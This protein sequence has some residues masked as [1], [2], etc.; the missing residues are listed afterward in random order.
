MSPNP[1]PDSNFKPIHPCSMFII[2]FV[3]GYN[4]LRKW[5][6][7]TEK[8][9]EAMAQQMAE[10]ASH[11]EGQ[12]LPQVIQDFTPFAKV[13]EV[14]MIFERADACS[15]AAAKQILKEKASEFKAR[16]TSRQ[17]DKRQMEK[18]LEAEHIRRAEE[19]IMGKSAARESREKE[20]SKASKHNVASTLG[21]SVISA[22]SHHQ[23]TLHDEI[24]KF[25]T[26]V[27]E[28]KDKLAVHIDVFC[29]QKN[30]I[31]T[32]DAVMAASSSGFEG[33]YLAVWNLI[34]LVEGD[35][36]DLY[37]KTVR[38]L[39][40][41]AESGPGR[42]QAKQM[43]VSDLAELYVQASEAKNPFDKFIKSVGEATGSKV[44]LPDKLKRI[45]R[46]FEKI[47][48]DPDDAFSCE[49]IADI[50]RAMLT[51]T[52]MQQIVKIA[53]AFLDSDEVVIV[54]IKDRF[55]EKPSAGGWRDLMINF[56]MADDPNR[57]V[58]EVQIVL[59]KMLVARKG[60]GGHHGYDKS[61][62]ALEIL[63]KGGV[64]DPAKR[65]ARASYL[66]DGPC[67]EGLKL[68]HLGY[69]VKD[70]LKAGYQQ[71]ELCGEGGA[72]QD[73]LLQ[74]QE[75][76]D[77]EARQK[78][79][80]GKV[81]KRVSGKYSRKYS[82]LGSGKA[83]KVAPG[84]DSSSD[85]PSG[86]PAPLSEETPVQSFNESFESSSFKSKLTS[87]KSAAIVTSNPFKLRKSPSK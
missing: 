37:V 75:A 73:E 34:V 49:K 45:S 7:R 65:W 51:A 22:F 55:V 29:S 74:A 60:L 59:E 50:I 84:E 35:H 39:K 40:L 42:G 24:F 82:R 86:Q 69:E 11:A 32:C 25:R 41:R 66:R 10:E 33:V 19:M 4:F 17:E 43:V 62:N 38:P 64:L 3:L 56:Y 70:L 8:L 12:E 67:I 72:T 23:D 68:L 61:R 21:G 14:S 78:K 1:E 83:A 77:K 31:K 76:I 44:S 80:G 87:L 13:P 52:S 57:H 46:V 54:R 58:C 79:S 6:L 20:K 27:S 16:R 18:D 81:R 26:E 5:R 63:E 53:I 15:S 85:R 2:A 30:I 28:A 48:F 47:L 9:R 71:A 36:L